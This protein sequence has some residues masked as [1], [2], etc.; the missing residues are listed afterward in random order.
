MEIYTIDDE[1]VYTGT[2]DENGKIVI[3]ELEYGKYYILEK[4]APEGYNLNTEKMYF[5]IKE[6]GQIVKC[7]MKDEKI[8]EVPNT[9]LNDL[10]IKE[11]GSIMLCVA[12]IGVIIYA[13]KKRK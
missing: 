13:K 4:N 12:G 2:T 8:I 7:T 10:H 9:E 3:E 11:I 6:D 1:L 5:E